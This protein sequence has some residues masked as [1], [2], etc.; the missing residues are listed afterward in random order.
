MKK[1]YFLLLVFCLLCHTK[2]F[3]QWD[4]YEK[5]HLILKKGDT[6][7]GFANVNE[8][9]RTVLFK[10]E[11]KKNKEKLNFS[12][13][14]EAKFTV[15]LDKKKTQKEE[16][17]LV[18][19]ILKEGD[20]ESKV[21]V[22]AELI[23]NKDDFKVYAV[24]GSSVHGIN[25]GIGA[26]V[27]YKNLN[28]QETN[29]SEYYCLVKDEKYARVIYKSTSLRAFTNSASDCFSDCKELEKKIKEKEFGKTEVTKIADFY[30][31]NCI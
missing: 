14:K 13:I 5:V 20:S 3:S 8:N 10:D 21:K 29:F 7:N 19:L 18:P 1:I 23:Y 17:T 6:L 15:Y 11:N 24:R 30:V 2:A 25:T 12:D 9:F 26:K 22:L 28:S 31:S 27:S 16:F 4:D